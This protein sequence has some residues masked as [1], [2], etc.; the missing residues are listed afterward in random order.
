MI[1]QAITSINDHLQIEFTPDERNK[2][3][4]Y[5]AEIN[6][7]SAND[8]IQ[9]GLSSQN[10]ISS[11]STTILNQIQTHELGAAQNILI[12]LRTDIKDF[13]QSASKKSFLF[14]FDSINKRIKRL[15]YRYAKIRDNIDA[16]ELKLERHY[17]E[18]LK[19]MNVF[20]SL[21]KENQNYFKE[22]SLYIAAGEEKIDEIK[23]TIL[24]KL[25]ADTE[26]SKEIVKAQ[27]YQD[28][29][30][31]LL[32]FE[33]K[34]HDLKLTRMIVLQ[35]V[36]QIR[37]IQNNGVALVEKIQSSIVNTLPLWKNQMVLTLGIVH[38]EKA[39]EAQKAIT[40]A[41]NQLLNK[42]SEML[43]NSSI[44]IAR[45][46]ERSIVDIETIRKVNTDIINAIDEIIKIQKEGREKRGIV[47]AELR[48]TE[49]ELR[50][51]INNSSSLKQPEL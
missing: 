20:D 37:M 28:M 44:N 36:P 34:I 43:K 40:D 14:F 1:T 11:F 24:P 16:I 50:K 30:Q 48:V 49:E 8:V 25:K 23:D 5:K 2:I 46:N 33:R 17:K 21:Y 18:L 9:Y 26:A 3:E 6:L 41:T 42:N 31:Q 39:V 47:E 13:D 19:D 32:R 38:S 22:L 29:E 51:V 7:T 4:K 45:E 12:D 27:Q 15:R 35:N 10:K